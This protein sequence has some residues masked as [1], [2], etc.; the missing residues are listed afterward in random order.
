MRAVSKLSKFVFLIAFIIIPSHSFA[1]AFVVKKTYSVD[2]ETI[3][4]SDK[5]SKVFSA[6]SNL[7][8]YSGSSQ[9]VTYKF[10][11]GTTNA[12]VNSSTGNSVTWGSDHVTKTTRYS[13][14]DGTTNSV[15]TNVPGTV[16][17]PTYSGSVESKVTTFG[18]GTTSTAIFN[19]TSNTK[20]YTGSNQTVTYRFADGTTNAV[21]NASTGNTVSW[22][23][24]HVTKTTRY[25]FADGTTNS[26]VTNI[27]GTV[28]SPT[29]SGSVE[30]KVTT[31]GDGATSTA[32]FNATSNSI[33]WGT[34]HVTKTTQYKFSDGTSNSVATTIQPTYSTPV[35]TAAVYAT[36]WS[37]T[38]K[39][40]PPSVSAY[41]ARYGDGFAST[42]QSGS[43]SLPFLQTTLTPN[44][45]SGTGAINDPNA[46]VL[47]PTNIS[48]NLTWGLPDKSGPLYANAFKSGSYTFSSPAN[49]WGNTVAGYNL[50]NGPTYVAPH[51]D[52]LDAWNKGW[53]GNKVNIVIADYL[54]QNH[55]VIVTS[56]VA[57]YAVGSNYYGITLDQNLYLNTNNVFKTDGTLA[58]LTTAQK[59]GVINTSFGANYVNGTSD[60][61][62]SIVD[63]GLATFRTYWQNALGGTAGYIYKGLDLT[64]AV[65][66]KAAG[67]DSIAA[68]KESF[69]KAFST[70]AKIGPRIIVVGALSF[71]NNGKGIISSYS[72]TAG[73]DAVVSSRFLLASGATPFNYGD[74]SINGY[75]VPSSD[76]GNNVGTS[77]AAP[78]IAGYSAIVR[79]KFP[80]LSGANTADI[81]L[82]TAR[83]D[84]LACYPNCDKTIYGQGEASLSR[85]LAPV[86]Y[87]K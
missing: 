20:T 86:G 40:T 85:A 14:A 53:T 10:A 43:V 23:T 71:D 19:S 9:T 18:D 73:T 69:V 78:R 34:D 4:Y 68:D 79:Q 42:L 7:K 70:D 55:G 81:L 66:T 76:F 58:N 48:Y 49:V 83:Y 54:G 61:Q 32:V 31:Y 8:S 26:V 21:V 65:V 41:A 1:A 64:D 17:A 6:T 24:D 50:N 60:Q 5:T 45:P 27:P 3:S 75:L 12:V 62:R 59:I 33:S 29:Y 37:S 80:N 11:D 36:N 51:P 67:N 38:G 16:G 30:T 44:G 84:T 15:V 35:L 13:F 47:S 72:N 77:Y 2:Q 63:S 39:V 22:A 28:G 82:A 57:R 52:V 46:F 56:L 25:K 74:V 87:L